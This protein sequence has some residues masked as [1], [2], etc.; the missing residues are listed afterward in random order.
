MKDTAA[1]EL[2]LHESQSK[3]NSA[4]HSLMVL[5]LIFTILVIAS[6]FINS[7]NMK[8]EY[9]RENENLYESLLLRA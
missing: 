5:A 6:F 4:F 7:I 8:K 2:Y 9:M 1:T 3:A